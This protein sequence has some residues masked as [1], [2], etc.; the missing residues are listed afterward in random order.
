MNGSYLLMGLIFCM[1]CVLEVFVMF[2]FGKLIKCIGYYGVLYL[3][4]VCYIIRYVLYLFFYNV[5]YVLVVE[6]LYGVIFGVMWVVIIFYG[7]FILFEGMRVIVMG[8]VMVTYFGL[9]K[10]IVGF[11]GGVMYS[12]YGLRIFF[13]SLVVISV[14]I[15]LLFVFS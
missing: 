6:F 9:G 5:W 12:S 11:G 4:F 8:L 13:R 14:I 7:G 1:I 3:M 2:F 10:F 15:C